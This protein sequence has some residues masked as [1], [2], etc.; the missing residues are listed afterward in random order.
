[1]GRKL[2]RSCQ[3]PAQQRALAK[4]TAEQESSSSASD[5]E[6]KDASLSDDK[7]MIVEV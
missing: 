3:V 7:I 5:S 4:A 1:M 2:Q 6:F